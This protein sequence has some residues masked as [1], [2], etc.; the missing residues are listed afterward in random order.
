MQEV[1]SDEGDFGIVLEGLP[2]KLLAY[3]FLAK[4][5]NKNS[6]PMQKKKKNRKGK[7]Y[8]THNRM[9]GVLFHTFFFFIFA[10]RYHG[11]NF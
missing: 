5:K 7:K 2:K 3:N 6:S 1:T 11:S 10:Q 4:I 9:I 8:F